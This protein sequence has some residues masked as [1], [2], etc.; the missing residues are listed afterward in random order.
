LNLAYEELL[1]RMQVGGITPKAPSF[2]TRINLHRN[3]GNTGLKT[4]ANGTFIITKHDELH[5]H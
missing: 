3:Q 1:L 5:I 4:G 2:T